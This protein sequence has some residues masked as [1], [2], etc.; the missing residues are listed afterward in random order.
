[1][2]EVSFQPMPLEPQEPP[3]E[4]GPVLGI[5]SFVLFVI[6]ILPLCVMIYMIY[7]TASQYGFD[8]SLATAESLQTLG[9]QMIGTMA[10]TVIF[11]LA[12]I[13]TGIASIFN[14]NQT[15]KIFG[16][17]GL[18]LNALVFL[19]LCCFLAYSLTLA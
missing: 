10:C 18:V 3:K 13:G 8:Q 19:G 1:M 5:I 14:S 15:G 6:S 11:N 4:K 16:I 2:N 9:L 17:L 12:G 7:S